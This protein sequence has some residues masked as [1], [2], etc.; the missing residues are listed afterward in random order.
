MFKLCSEPKK[1]FLNQL[2]EAIEYKEKFVSEL[3]YE[4]KNSKIDITLSNPKFRENVLTLEKLSICLSFAYAFIYFTANLF[5][6]LCLA[7]TYLFICLLIY[8]LYL[9]KNSK[10]SDFILGCT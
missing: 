8:L 6:L 1:A 9:L 3:S 10:N 4:I 2:K 5:C 7:Y